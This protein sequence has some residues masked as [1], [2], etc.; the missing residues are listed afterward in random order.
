MLS[1][2]KMYAFQ[3]ETA[4]NEKNYSYNT[5]IKRQIPKFKNEQ[6]FE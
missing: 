5:I 1:N 3:K 4:E 6:K 2:L